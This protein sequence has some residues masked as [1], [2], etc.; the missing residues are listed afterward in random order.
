MEH[1]FVVILILSPPGYSV[2][3]LQSWLVFWISVF[4]NF[5]NG[6]PPYVF[7]SPSPSSRAYSFSFYSLSPF[8]RLPG[9]DHYNFFTCPICSVGSY[10]YFLCYFLVSYYRQTI[11]RYL[12]LYAPFIILQY[13]YKPTRRTKFLWLDFIFYQMLYMFRTV[14]VHHQEQLL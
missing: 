7:R 9:S 5:R 8:L 3:R 2:V 12:T 6:L 13:L 11:N 1:Q 14:L 4:Q 10:S